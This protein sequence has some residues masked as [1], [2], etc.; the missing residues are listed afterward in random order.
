MKIV[1]QNETQPAVIKQNQAK[2]E[3]KHEEVISLLH[4]N[5]ATQKYKRLEIIWDQKG[6]ILKLTEGKKGEQ[7]TTIAFSLNPQELAYLIL[8]LNKLFNEL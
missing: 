2:H 8:K 6:I 7:P 3:A 5:E 1:R 4:Y